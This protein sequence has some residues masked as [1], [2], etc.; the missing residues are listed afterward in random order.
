MRVDDTLLERMAEKRLL[1]LSDAM[2]QMYKKQYPK[3]CKIIGDKALKRFCKHCVDKA[4]AYGANNY[5]E[6]KVYTSLAWVLGTGFDDDPLY[7]WI[8]ETLAE[9]VAFEERV[10]EITDRVHELYSFTTLEQLQVYDEALKRLLQLNFAAIKKFTS[11]VDIVRTLEHVYPQRAEALGGSE[12]LKEHLKRACYQKTIRYNIDHPIGIFVYAGLVFFLGH[13]VDDDPLYGWA[14]KY[15][16]A[17]EPRMAHKLDRLI[18]VI[19][20]RVRNMRREIEITM[21][22]L[23]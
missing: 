14:N 21:E 13:Q 23:K 19:E 6:L 17:D 12:V 8:A 18:K 4:D 16:N 20:K 11:Y 3:Q 15:L 2:V 9:D 5:G 22:E 7:P 1:E 10:E